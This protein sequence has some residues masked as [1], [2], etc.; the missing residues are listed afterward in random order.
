V[1]TL[2]LQFLG[3]GAAVVAAGIALAKAGDALAAGTRLGGLWVGSLLLAGATSLP[4]LATDVVAVRIGA[5][6]LAAGD[7]FGSSMANMLILALVDLLSPRGR[8]LR[9]AALEHV[10]A[11]SLAIVLNGLAAAFVLIGS[12]AA[13]LGT[14]LDALL[15][16]A[17][18]AAGMRAVYRHG[19]AAGSTAVG[20]GPG[21]ERPSLRGAALRFGLAALAI[22]IA[23]PWFARSAHGIAEAT[24]LGGTFV[25]TLLVGLATSLPELASSAAAVRIGALDLAVGNLLGSNG[26]NMAVFLVLDFA[27]PGPIFAALDPAHAITGLF[28]VV[29]MAIGMAALVYRTERR[30]AM[31][32]P[33]SLAILACYLLAVGLLYS[34]TTGG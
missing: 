33:S 12:R 3:S 14:G 7:L 31:L 21:R 23:A 9:G 24:G 27:H 2:V 17:L 26:F 11:G 8:V 5:L 29:L 18:Y 1:T 19:R 34:R 4:E 32:E 30:F 20:P 13:V 22:L 10:L 25:G 28:A 16:C 6:D 15:L